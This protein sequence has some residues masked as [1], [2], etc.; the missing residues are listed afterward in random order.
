[1]GKSKS[2]TM[3]SSD[4]RVELGTDGAG[5]GKKSPVGGEV[6]GADAGQQGVAQSCALEFRS[7]MLS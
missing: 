5:F 7:T 3:Y 4:A 6:P 2:A 1:M